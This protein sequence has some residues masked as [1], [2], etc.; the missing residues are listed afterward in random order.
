[1][2]QQLS[3]GSD[4][5]IKP[6]SSKPPAV[7]SDK[8]SSKLSLKGKVKW[9]DMASSSSSTSSSSLVSSEDSNDDILQ[10]IIVK[11]KTDKKEKGKA[12]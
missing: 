5:P 4:S 12:K 11:S 9:A 3:T 1:M 8:S 7:S 2:F 6:S 10:S